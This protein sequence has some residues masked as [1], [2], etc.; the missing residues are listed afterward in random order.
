MKELSP[1]EAHAEFFAEL[2]VDGIRL[3]PSWRG[4]D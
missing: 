2:G 1:L 4:T 3:E